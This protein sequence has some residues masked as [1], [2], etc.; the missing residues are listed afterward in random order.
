M[1]RLVIKVPE[2]KSSLVRQI[3]RGL[4][5]VVLQDNNVSHSSYKQK[6]TSISTWDDDE[7]KKIEESKKSFQSLKG[8]QW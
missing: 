5:V 3:L 6:L 2:K 4:G 7:V 8:E 1:E